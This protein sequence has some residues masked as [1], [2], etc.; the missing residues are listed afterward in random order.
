M[1]LKD[2]RISSKKVYKKGSPTASELTMG[3]RVRER[4]VGVEGFEP[5]TLCL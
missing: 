2:A 5:P 4:E 3:L 1:P